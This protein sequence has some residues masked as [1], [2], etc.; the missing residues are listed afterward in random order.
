MPHNIKTRKKLIG[1]EKCFSSSIKKA[2]KKSVV[3]YCRS[4]LNPIN[5]NKKRIKNNE[6][7]ITLFLL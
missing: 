1:S 4:K 5:P 6:N 2:K 3:E 7:T